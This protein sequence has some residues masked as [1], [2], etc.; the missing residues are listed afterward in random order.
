MCL[1]ARQCESMNI[2]TV[3]GF[4]VVLK[5]MGVPEYANAPLSALVFTPDSNV[6][7]HITDRPLHIFA[8]ICIYACAHRH[9]SVCLTD[10]RKNNASDH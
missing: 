10:L 7:K 9:T 5:E 2:D 8:Y 3:E 1:Y 4:L 6:Y